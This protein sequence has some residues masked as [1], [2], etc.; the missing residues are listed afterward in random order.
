MG[1]ATGID[2]SAVCGPLTW[3]GNR[4][5]NRVQLFF[6]KAFSVQVRVGKSA[7]ASM[8]AVSRGENSG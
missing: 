5:K 7:V 4:I 3:Q 8:Y 1:Y 6:G 2:C